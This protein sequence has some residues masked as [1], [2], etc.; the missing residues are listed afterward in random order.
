MSSSS[1]NDCCSKELDDFGNCCTGDACC[2]SR[3]HSGAVA[4]SCVC[5]T[6]YVE[7]IGFSANDRR[8]VAAP[9]LEPS[10]WNLAY[11]APGTYDANMWICLNRHPNGT[12]QSNGN[13]VKVANNGTAAAGSYGVALGVQNVSS[14]KFSYSTPVL[15]ATTGTP[16]GSVTQWL[17]PL[18]VTFSTT[19]LPAGTYR[20]AVVADIDGAVGESDG[21]NNLSAGAST[22]YLN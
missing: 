17:G 1:A 5:D 9:D 13:M 21:T 14:G 8:C 7:S 18:C 6:G 2:N 19:S 20:L 15:V 3:N 16:A 12:A 11:W 22:F 10:D 4:S